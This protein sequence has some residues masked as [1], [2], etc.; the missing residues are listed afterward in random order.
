MIDISFVLIWMFD[1]YMYL[2]KH[3]QTVYNRKEHYII[4]NPSLAKHD[5]HAL[6]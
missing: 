3:L 1:S 6:S 2:Y 5:R 4:V